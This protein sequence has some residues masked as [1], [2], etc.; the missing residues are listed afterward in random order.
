M[1]VEAMQAGKNSLCAICVALG[2]L[3]AAGEIAACDE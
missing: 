1:G 2:D 3:C